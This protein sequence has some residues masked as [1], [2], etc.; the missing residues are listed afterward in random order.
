MKMSAVFPER[1]K[2]LRI[3]FLLPLL[4]GAKDDLPFFSTISF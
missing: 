2:A 3:N 1:G 4:M